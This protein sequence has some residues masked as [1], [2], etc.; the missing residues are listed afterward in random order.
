[1]LKQSIMSELAW[2][3]WQAVYTLRRNGI[4]QQILDIR[5]NLLARKSMKTTTTML[6][7]VRYCVIELTHT[8]AL[9]EKWTVRHA[10][11]GMWF[12]KRIS[13]HSFADEQQ[14]LAYAEEIKQKNALLTDA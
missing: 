8:D 10:T 2:Q 7:N 5:K 12:K 4:F 14:A 9:P 3:K 1:M 11:R 13:S 6:S